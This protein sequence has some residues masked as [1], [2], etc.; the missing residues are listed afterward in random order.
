M[1]KMGS[2]ISLDPCLCAKV[3]SILWTGVAYFT[4]VPALRINLRR[5]QRAD[6]DADGIKLCLSNACGVAGD[7]SIGVA[8][9]SNVNTVFASWSF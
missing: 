8:P 3:R 5:V 9:F 7:R 2:T 6:S 1:L 4:L